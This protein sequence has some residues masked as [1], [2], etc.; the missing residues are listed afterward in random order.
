MSFKVEYDNVLI[1]LVIGLL[2]CISA[3]ARTMVTLSSPQHLPPILSDLAISPFIYSSMIPARITLG[4][5]VTIRFV[6]T[7]TNNQSFV[8]T[9]TMYIGNVTLMID[10]ELEA[11][12]SKTASHTIT[13]DHVGFYNVEVDGLTG[14]F[15]VWPLERKAAGFEVSKLRLF[16]EIEEDVDIPIFVNV[17]NIGDVEG[18]H[19]VDLILDGEVVYSENVTLPTGGSEEIPLWIKGGLPAGTYQIEVERLTGSFTVTPEPSLWDIIPGFPYES[20]MLGLVFG[21]L[22]I[23]SYSVSR[24]I[25]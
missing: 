11:Y 23:W 1:C 8:Y 24:S 6:V 19:Q 13:P 10:I 25:K 9:A 18:T 2:V 14:C 15:Y 3:C 5:N 16:T 17:S 7:N 12:E 4:D 21:L 22:I 20:I